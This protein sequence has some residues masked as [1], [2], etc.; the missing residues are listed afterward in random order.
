[1]A[2]KRIC[3]GRTSPRAW[4]LCRLSETTRPARNA[5]RDSD[6]PA[7]AVSAAVPTQ[8]AMTESRNTSGEQAR[9]TASNSF[10]ITRRATTSVTAITAAAVA[11]ARSSWTNDCPSPAPSCGSTSTMTTHRQVLEHQE[12]QCGLTGDRTGLRAVAQ[13]LEHDRRR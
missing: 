4:V 9:A 5:P 10:G 3:K 8:I 1:M 12:G 2:E 13:Q 7:S 11:S 6:T